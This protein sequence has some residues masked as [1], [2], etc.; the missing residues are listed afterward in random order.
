MLLAVGIAA[1]DV[2]VFDRET[3]E[4]TVNVVDD[5]AS[6]ATE[7]ASGSRFGRAVD[8]ARTS[9]TGPTSIV[10]TAG[11]STVAVQR[12][13]PDEA[14][15]RLDRLR[16]TASP[17]DLRRA[18]S[19]AGALAG[20]DARVVV[21]NGFAGDDWVDPVATLRARGVLVSLQ[22]FGDGGGANVGVDRRFSGANVTL[23]VQNFGGDPVT[24]T[25]EFGGQ[26]AELSLDSGAIHGI[27]IDRVDGDVVLAEFGAQVRLMPMI[28]MFH[29]AYGDRLG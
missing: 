19:E 18:I 28:A 22:Q 24:G 26:R 12:G 15:D 8:A 17:G 23:S 11:G 14:R 10:S 6:M 21:L 2:P 3:V 7:T 16:V 1:P 4:E 13:T 29:A 5:S 27:R 9:V 25:V 20:E